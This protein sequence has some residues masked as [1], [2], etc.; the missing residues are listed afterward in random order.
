M[1]N[2]KQNYQPN[3]EEVKQILLIHHKVLFLISKVVK[4]QYFGIIGI[5]INVLRAI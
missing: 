4:C 1:R 5:I 2:K 3:Y